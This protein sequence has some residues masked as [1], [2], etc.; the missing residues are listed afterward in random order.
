[1]PISNEVLIESNQIQML[2]RAA[3]KKRASC[4]YAL[5]KGRFESSYC[6]PRNTCAIWKRSL[7]SNIGLFN[8]RLDNSGGMEDYEMVLRA[9]RHLELFPFPLEKRIG[10]VMRE[11]NSFQQKIAMENQAIQTIEASYPKQVVITVKEHLKALH[12]ECE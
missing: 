9:F 11:P 5:F 3:G 1:M 6:V 12:H 10:L 8:E 4:G 2:L 7:F